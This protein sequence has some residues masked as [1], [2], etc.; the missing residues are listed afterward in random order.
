[1]LRGSVRMCYREEE[2][3]K[4]NK[5][6][7]EKTKIKLQK[8]TM[9]K[10]MKT[11]NSSEFRQW[12]QEVLGGVKVWT[13]ERSPSPAPTPDHGNVNSAALEGWRQPEVAEKATGSWWKRPVKVWEEGEGEE[14]IL[15]FG[16]SL[17]SVG[18][19]VEDRAAGGHQ[20]PAPW[21]NTFSFKEPFYK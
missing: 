20:D 2:E 9:L 14:D 16:A 15:G 7:K 11:D 18:L 5:H 8:G 12:K 13:H 19:K 17:F 21:Y 3:V 6:Q 1:M 4:E 10:F